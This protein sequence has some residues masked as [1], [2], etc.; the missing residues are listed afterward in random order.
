MDVA[1][2]RDDHFHS[3]TEAIWQWEWSE[4]H[5]GWQAQVVDRASLCEGRQTEKFRRRLALSPAVPW[6]TSVDA[7]HAYVVNLYP[8]KAHVLL[9]G[10]D[11]ELKIG[12][13]GHRCV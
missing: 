2:V 8:I 12:V 11:Y 10:A 1:T 13:G 3:T 7:R 5:H 4:P 6:G 9:I